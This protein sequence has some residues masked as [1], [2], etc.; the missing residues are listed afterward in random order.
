MAISEDEVARLHKANRPSGQVH[1][2][3]ET[4]KLIIYSYVERELQFICGRMYKS[5][6]RVDTHATSSE[7]VLWWISALVFNLDLI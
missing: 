4:T 7:P 3:T 1:L 5:C 2:C 6:R